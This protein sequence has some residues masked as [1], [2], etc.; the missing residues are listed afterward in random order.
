MSNPTTTS[1]SIKFQLAVEIASWIKLLRSYTGTIFIPSGM[2]EANSFNLSLMRPITCN[3]SSPKRMMT[4]PPT[5][6]PWPFKSTTPRRISEP[7]CTVATSRSKIGVPLALVP[8]AIFSI[9]SVDLMYPRP[10]IMYSTPE[11][12][13]TRPPVSLLLMRIFSTISGTDRL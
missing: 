11:N 7:S 5:A 13:M 9:S 2:A 12:S 6:S 3:T 10:R 8:T 1:S 4:I